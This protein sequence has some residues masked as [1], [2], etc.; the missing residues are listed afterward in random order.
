MPVINRIAGY[1]EDMAAW[2]H[3]LHRNPELSF[4]CHRTAAFVADRLREFA[5]DEIPRA[6]RPPASSPS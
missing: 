2:R 4:D 1:A 3:W 5:V 6:S